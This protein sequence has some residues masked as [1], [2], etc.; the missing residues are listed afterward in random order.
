MNEPETIFSDERITRL[1]ID[2]ILKVGI[3]FALFIWCFDIISPFLYP[4]IWGIVIAVASHGSYQRL[5]RRIGDRPI[6]AAVLFS[7]I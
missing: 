6:L 5:N 4:I 7:L 2:T 3:L 1:V